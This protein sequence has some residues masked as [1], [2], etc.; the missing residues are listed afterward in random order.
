MANDVLAVAGFD[1]SSLTKDIADH[2]RAAAHRIRRQEQKATEAIFEIG[3]DLLAIK[4]ML[5]HG[6]FIRWV[7]AECMSAV[8]TA[9]NYMRAAQ[10]FD[11]KYETVSHLAPTTVYALASAPAEARDEIVL[12]LEAGERPSEIQIK[13][14][15]WSARQKFKAGKLDARGSSRRRRA[16]KGAEDKRR[17]AVARMEREN[18]LREQALKSAADIIRDGLGARVSELCILLEAASEHAL[19]QH[20]RVGGIVEAA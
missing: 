11:G 15:I 16:K 20:L 10:A 2:A 12:K 17:K 14:R 4:Q 5:E 1:Y 6:Q 18:A 19:L 13:D 3:R 9:Q 7:E 8:R